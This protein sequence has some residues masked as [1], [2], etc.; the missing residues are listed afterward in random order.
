MAGQTLMT[1]EGREAR[2]PN[3]PPPYW[4]TRV[5]GTFNGLRLRPDGTKQAPAGVEPYPVAPSGAGS[6]AAP[7]GPRP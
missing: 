6:S 2:I 5:N 4:P 7:S 3:S 1:I